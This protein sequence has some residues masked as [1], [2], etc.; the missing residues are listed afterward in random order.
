MQYEVA[1]D[2]QTELRLLCDA[3]HVAVLDALAAATGTDRT[4]VV[5]QIIRDHV[6]REVTRAVSVCRVIR[7]N[8]LASETE[9]NRNGK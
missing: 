6:E 7:L 4:S 1:D 2:K 8:P 5:R 9:W 3:N